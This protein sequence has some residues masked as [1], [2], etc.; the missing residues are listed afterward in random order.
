[1]ED[2][3]WYDED[4]WDDWDL[5]GADEPR[6]TYK[7]A[8]ESLRALTKDHADVRVEWNGRRGPRSDARIVFN[9]TAGSGGLRVRMRSAAQF[10][11]L[12]RII[13]SAT[14]LVGN[15]AL[16]YQPEQIIT[17]RLVGDYDQFRAAVARKLAP[18]ES[19]RFDPDGPLGRDVAGMLASVGAFSATEKVATSASDPRA[20]RLI[21]PN[22]DLRLLYGPHAPEVPSVAIELA[23]FSVPDP[24]HAAEV[25]QEFATAYLYKLGKATGV[26]LRLLQSENRIGSRK[27]PADSGDV[28]FP[29]RRYDQHPAELYAAGN[30]AA[31]DPVERYLKY[32]QVL[33]FYMPKAANSV[34]RAQNVSVEQA[35][36]PLRRPPNRLGAERNK[37]DAVISEAVSP[38]QAAS[39]LR[40]KDLFAVLSNPQVIQD[41]EVLIADVFGHPVTG[42]DYRLEISKRIYDVRTR[43]VHMKEGGGPDGKALLA[44]Y[45]REARDLAAD[46][47]LVRFLAEHAMERWSEPLA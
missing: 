20:I 47:R 33:E 4:P 42:H 37:L 1:V 39:L 14:P 41:A 19:R 8:V 36:S 43:I 30:S 25:L 16:W 45:G 31:R 6:I 11:G 18:R 28:R 24:A 10:E 38:S 44:P 22:P 15:L 3:P 17:A 23:G 13:T 27:R 12:R 32:F 46:L 26:S 9:G 40:D 2:G 34:A 5:E 21:A 29:K 35:T 7:Q